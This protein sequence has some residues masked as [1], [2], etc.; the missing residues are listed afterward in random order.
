MNI[1]IKPLVPF[2]FIFNLVTK[3]CNIWFSQEANM[4]DS[5]TKTLKIIKEFISEA[6]I[7]R[8][9]LIANIIL[10]LISGSKISLYHQLGV[11]VKH[12][13][14]TLKSGEQKIRRLLKCFPITSKTYA[15][16]VIIMFA[17]N[18]VEL[19]IDRTNWMFGKVDINFL[20]LSLR[21]HNIAIPIYRI[22]LD[23]KDGNSSS[24]QRIDL[25]K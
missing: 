20:V 1:K 9:W 21:W 25:I 7:E 16:T 13:K 5:V 8:A 19:I 23:N 12:K 17:V 11:S 3:Y 15:K 22:M 6:R 10:L 14:A 2:N 24:Q 4:Q 18:S